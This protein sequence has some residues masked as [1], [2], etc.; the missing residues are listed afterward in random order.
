MSRVKGS[1]PSSQ[2]DWSQ[3]NASFFSQ[4]EHAMRKPHPTMPTGPWSSTLVPRSII[5]VTVFISIC[6]TFYYLESIRELRWPMNNTHHFYPYHY[7]KYFL[8]E[9]AE[10]LIGINISY[11]CLGGMSPVLKGISQDKTSHLR[12]LNLTTSITQIKAKHL[13]M[14][15]RGFLGWIFLLFPI[16]LFICSLYLLNTTSLPAPTI[17]QSLLSS[18]FLFASERAEVS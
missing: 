3:D 11:I 4:F 17:I 15:M 18:P 12:A 8:D 5:P 9:Q 16:N 14:P 1:Q 7:G 2:L 6:L 10:N 13:E